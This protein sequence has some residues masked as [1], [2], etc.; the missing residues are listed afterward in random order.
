MSGIEPPSQAWEARIIT[1]I[2][3]SLGF[4][5][6]KFIF[7]NVN[8]CYNY[9]CMVRQSQ[10]FVRIIVFFLIL[11]LAQAAGGF[12]YATEAGELTE[13]RLYFINLDKPT[14]AKGYTVS[15]FNDTIKLSLTPDILSEP[16]GVD[17]I[18][19]NE[20][21]DNPWRLERISK[22]YQFEFRNKSAYDNKKPFY[23]QFSYDQASNFYKQ[24][25]YYDKNY[26]AWRPLPTVDY[27]NESFVRS[28]IHLPFARIAVFSNPEAMVIG[29]ASWY[30]YKGGLFAASPDFPQG[31]KLRVYNLDNN[32]YVDVAVNDFGPERKLHPN[33]AIDL[34]KI[35]FAKIAPIGAGIINVR[36]EPIGIVPENNRILHIAETGAGVNLQITAKSA[37][38]MDEQTGDILWQKNAT[39]ALPLA[40]LTKLVAIK[41]FLD[42][43]PSLNKV[44]AYSARDE[45]YNYQYVNKWESARIKLNDGDT[46]T[47]EDLLYA[48]LVGSANN[49]I[50]S[51]VRVSGLARD[52]FIKTM[53]EVAASWGASATHFIEPTGLSPL[54]VSSAFDYAIITKEVYTNLIIQKA[55]TMAKYKFTTLNTKE[56]HTL[57]NTDKLLQTSNL[58]ITGSKTGYLVEAQYC[59]MARAIDDKGRQVIA[60]TMGVDGRDKSFVETED[61][62]KYGL[63]KIVN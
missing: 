60:V 22:V 29:Q 45:E 47:I 51:L 17:V 54:N 2:L 11:L 27:P 24:V 35:A 13:N 1:I 10:M 7:Y 48:A 53:N 40:S 14:I 63:K 25:F 36:I 49:A 28:L 20:V 6:I 32:K 62:L 26:S 12:V 8:L 30:K 3:H 44:V 33:R 55:S 57:T 37:I 38:A 43:K 4:I 15:A 39:S 50:E 58:Y 41:V 56:A 9:I 46:L 19:L 16:T 59:L 18:E 21:I 42:T 31:S 34:D 23:I 52:E 61:L 5:N